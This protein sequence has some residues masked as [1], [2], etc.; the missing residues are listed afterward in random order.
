LLCQGR[1]YLAYR[2]YLAGLVRSGGLA[3]CA[4]R[5]RERGSIDLIATAGPGVTTGPGL[6][7]GCTRR[8]GA[9]R[10]SQSSGCAA[11]ASSA[12]SSAIAGR[13]AGSLARQRSISGL[14]SGGTCPSDGL[15]YTTRYSSADGRPAPNGGRPEAANASTPPRLKMSAAGLTSRPV[16]C[17]GDMKPGE[18]TTRPLPDSQLASA[19]REMPK[20]MIRGPSMASSTFDGFRSRC[21]RPVA[22]TAASPPASPAA[23]VRTAVTLNGP[24]LATAPAN[25]GPAT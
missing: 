2:G 5:A 1:A 12:S 20:S 4:S 13:A 18:P 6:A 3:S 14:I 17:S 9:C 25:D 24:W 22:C 7:A 15:L 8:N 11:S 21:T 10:D 19:G 23:S 16:A